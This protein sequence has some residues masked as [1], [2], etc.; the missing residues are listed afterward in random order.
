MRREMF[1]L[2]TLRAM[3]GGHPAPSQARSQHHRLGPHESHTD[4]TS[5]DDVHE[6]IGERGRG[7]VCGAVCLLDAEATLRLHQAV[8][9]NFAPW[10]SGVA[11]ANLK[12]GPKEAQAA[13]ASQAIL[14]SKPHA[15]G[16]DSHMCLLR[17]NQGRNIGLAAG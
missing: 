11:E 16:Q 13:N 3:E 4:T 9:R 6:H 2:A 7:P 15:R 17:S 14:A 10:A 8:L 5:L 1:Q 12:L